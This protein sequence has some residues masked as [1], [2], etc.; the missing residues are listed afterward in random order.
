MT[1]EAGAFEE[2]NDISN[3]VTASKDLRDQS[4]QGDIPVKGATSDEQPQER[5]PS[6]QDFTHWS[7]SSDPEPTE[8]SPADIIV[9]M[10]VRSC[11]WSSMGDRPNK[12]T[13]KK[14]Q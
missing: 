7:T 1:A 8:L 6:R 11:P 13:Q 9:N 4:R 14:A 3:R 2:H 12:Y 10:L 5:C